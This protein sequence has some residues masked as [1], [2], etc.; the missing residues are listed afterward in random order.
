MVRSDQIKGGEIAMGHVAALVIGLILLVVGAQGAIRLL[1]DHDNGGILRWVPGGFAVQLT[2]F[3]VM[4]VGGLFLAA[5]A[6]RRSP[7][8]S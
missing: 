1:V 7:D 6:K 3:V 4:A 8:A 2:C 5:W